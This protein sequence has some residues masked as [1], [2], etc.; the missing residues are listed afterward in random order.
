MSKLGY[1]LCYI[2]VCLA[3]FLIGGMLLNTPN[4]PVEFIIGFILGWGGLLAL[5]GGAIKGL[6][7]LFY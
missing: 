3:A 5:I 1:V 2:G 6:K 7:S 4:G